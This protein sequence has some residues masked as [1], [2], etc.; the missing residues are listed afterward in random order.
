M[1]ALGTVGTVGPS[2]IDLY[3]RASQLRHFHAL[4]CALHSACACC[5]PPVACCMLHV[6]ILGSLFAAALANCSIF[7]VVGG[8]IE[9]IKI[10]R[11]DTAGAHLFEERSFNVLQ[12]A[13]VHAVYSSRRLRALGQS[14][15]A[16]GSCVCAYLHPCLPL[17]LRARARARERGCVCV[18]RCLLRSSAVHAVC[19]L[20]LRRTVRTSDSVRRTASLV[21][22]AKTVHGRCCGIAPSPNGLYFAALFDVSLRRAHHEPRSPPQRLPPLQE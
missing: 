10:R 11:T 4:R 19:C 5:M 2:M 16:R 20:L 15:C 18:W 22:S 7:A 3:L 12:L 6:H 13:P 1:G 14:V 8:S 9:R 17:S 21:A